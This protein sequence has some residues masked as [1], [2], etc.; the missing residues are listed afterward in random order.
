[1]RN[2]AYDITP[3]QATEFVSDC[4]E[5]DVIPFLK[6]SPGTGKSSIMRGVASKFM[7][8]LID[9]RISTS[10]P[11]DFSGLPEFRTLADGSRR[12]TFAPFDGIF[13]LED[14]P[15][16]EGYDGWM[17]FMDEFNS[18]REDVLAASY[19]AL[20]DR[21]TGNYHFN[22]RLRI[23][24]AG[25]HEDDGA[26]VNQIGTALKSRVVTLNMKVNTPEWIED[27]AIPQ[28]YDPRIIA[29]LMQ[30]PDDIDTFDPKS[31][32]DSFNSP[33][34][35]E[36]MNRLITGKTFKLDKV[37]KHGIQ[38]EVYEMEKK[39]PL[40]V[41]TMTPEKAVAFV[42]FT[43]V[44][45][46]IPTLAEVMN[47]PEGCRIPL[48]PSSCWATICSL[49][50]TIDKDNIEKLSIYIE[51]FDMTN[52]ILFYKSMMTRNQ[53]LRT[54]PAFIK[55]MAALNKYIHG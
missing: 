13:P 30:F 39:M 40:Y 36:F 45:S 55:A 43:K 47:N 10:Q 22:K 19:K 17:L 9:Q 28:N 52:K 51:R 42:S 6:G 1:M 41:G 27:V 8:S 16:P 24:A 25:N 12:A 54:H 31:Q 33:R 38:S 32:D 35:W 53:S 29:Y 20:L 4:V 44:F 23:T 34:T 46:E 50:Q 3:R 48:D 18:G 7:L 37:I 2:E 26:I 15:V 21:M 49:M 11:E 5:A 14:T